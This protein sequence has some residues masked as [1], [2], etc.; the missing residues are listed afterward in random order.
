MSF[1]DQAMPVLSDALVPPIVLGTAEL[2]TAAYQGSGHDA[3]M[4]RIDCCAASNPPEAGDAAWA[5]DAGIAAQLAFRRGEGL[6]LQDAALAA[7]Q[8]YRINGAP[9][10]ALR[11][12]ALAGPGDLMTNTPLDFLTNHLNVRL[13]LCTCYRTGHCRCSSPITT[14]PSSA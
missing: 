1:I 4:D 7:S 6:N 3:L 14:S 9:Q 11:L 12:L 13:D 10:G 8:L 2:T 5:H